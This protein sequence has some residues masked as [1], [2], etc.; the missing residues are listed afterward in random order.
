MRTFIITK[1]LACNWITISICWWITRW[2]TKILI[3]SI[4]T[5]R[6]FLFASMI[7]RISVIWTTISNTKPN[8]FRH[9]RNRYIDYF[10][11]I[12][13]SVRAIIRAVVGNWIT[14]HTNS[15]TIINANIIG[16]IVKEIIRIWWGWNLCIT[17]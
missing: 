5:L 11:S 17:I 4:S 7:W 15:T 6:T 8:I 10:T 13:W 12:I 3:I 14:I 2:R 16:V 1:V 9:T